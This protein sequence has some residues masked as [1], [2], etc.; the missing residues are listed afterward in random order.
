MLGGVRMIELGMWNDMIL[1]RIVCLLLL[2]GI[3]ESGNTLM[4]H[5]FPHHSYNRSI[6]DFNQYHRWYSMACVSYGMAQ[7][8]PYGVSLINSTAGT[9]WCV[10]LMSQ[11]SCQYVWIE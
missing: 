5:H 1:R 10:P 3:L 4:I 11:H 9:I 7:L 2:E 8:A 6:C